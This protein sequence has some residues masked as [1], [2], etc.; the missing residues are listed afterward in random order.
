VS[1]ADSDLAALGETK[2]IEI[3]TRS[4]TGTVH[5]ATVWPHVRDGVHYLRSYKGP[6]GR[7]FRDV[8]G[9]PAITLSGDGVRV[10]GRAVVVDDVAGIEACSAALRDKYPGSY[11]L[12]AMLVPEVLPTTVRIEPA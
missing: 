2:E 7:W 5:Q 11:S 6:A 4:A 9:D 10:E 12:E 1:F 8:L 3:E